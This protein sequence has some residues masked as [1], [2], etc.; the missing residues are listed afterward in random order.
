MK[1]KTNTLTIY[2]LKKRKSQSIQSLL[3]SIK[4]LS[5][6]NNNLNSAY[7]KRRTG[8]VILIFFISNV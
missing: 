2:K 6:T 5:N 4:Q 8:I 7:L 3:N 1:L